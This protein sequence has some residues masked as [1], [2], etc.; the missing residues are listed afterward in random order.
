MLAQ[1]SAEGTIVGFQSAGQFHCSPDDR[2]KL[3]AWAYMWGKLCYSAGI[4]AVVAVNIDPELYARIAEQVREGRY[5]DLAQFLDLAAR[6]QLALEANPQ[7][8]L[9]LA[10]AD[11]EQLVDEVAE[12]R[13][14]PSELAGR[15]SRRRDSVARRAG[16]WRSFL[17]RVELPSER[18]AAPDVDPAIDHVLWG[19][20]NRLLPVAVGV[21]VLAN[22]LGEADEFPVTTWHEQATAVATALRDDLRRWD[23]RADRAHGTRW[24]TAFPERKESSAQRYINQFLGTPARDGRSDGGAAFLGLVTISGSGDKACVTL[25][26]NGAFWAS[27]PNPIFDGDGEPESTFSEEEVRFFLRHL[28]EFRVGEYR[29]LNT[30]AALVAE[31]LSREEQNEAIA[32]AYPGWQSVASTMRAGAIGRL[33]D[34]GLLERTRHGLKVEYRLS[35]LAT[36]LGLPEQKAVVR[37]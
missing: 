28:R 11:A 3:A 1:V 2:S 35:P 34:L 33:G 18:F 30:M 36:S 32:R 9:P 6:N 22:L 29:F 21:R 25:T 31:G 13:I 23:E 7:A 16:E 15:G 19:Q 37:P 20:T 27:L 14:G 17:T 24:A 10:N 26:S 12:R 4:L 8:A 5:L